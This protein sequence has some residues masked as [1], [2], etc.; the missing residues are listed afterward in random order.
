[1]DAIVPGQSAV[2]LV[3][4]AIVEVT[5]VNI[6]A[7]NERKLPPPATEFSAPA[8]SATENRSTMCD[9]VN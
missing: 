4:L 3:A 5:P 6:S 1:V 2:V 8:T 9:G 7:G